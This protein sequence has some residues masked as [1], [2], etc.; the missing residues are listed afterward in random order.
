MEKRFDVLCVGGLVC[1]FMIKPV[2][3]DMFQ[4]DACFIDTIE[5]NVG[6]DAANESVVMSKL[7]MKVGLASEV[8]D[9]STGKDVL[10]YLEKNGVD[11]S[12]VVVRGNKKTRTNIVNIEAGGERHFLIF[13]MEFDEFGGDDLNYDVLKD[14]RMVSVGSIHA[15]VGL[16]AALA[17]YLKAAKEAGCITS[18]DMVSN[19]TKQ[20]LEETKKIIA[21]LDYLI[22]SEGEAE[23]L[24]GLKDPKEMAD[25]LLSWGAKNVIIKLGEK[26]CY[27]KNAAEEFSVPIFPAKAIDTTGAGD[28]F[29]GSFLT[30][31]L[32]GWD[33]KKCAHFACATGSIAVQSIGA[34]TGLKDMDQVI[35]VM[36][37]NNRWM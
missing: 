30:A 36:K 24:T 22:P 31:V 17:D 7:G 12:N 21:Q 15:Y 37:E 14:T 9:D 35:S 5:T 16:D 19:L 29:T 33:L 1:D 28:N 20:P 11:I 18:A 8:G 32:M 4:K 27:V 3:V 25:C 34:T 26:G 13:P 6:G 2:P 23:E 10:A